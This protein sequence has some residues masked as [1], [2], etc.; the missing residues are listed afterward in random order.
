M[1]GPMTLLVG[2]LF[3]SYMG[4]SV[5]RKGKFRLATRSGVEHV[6]LG[7]VLGPLVLGIIERSWTKLFEPI[8]LVGAAWLGFLAGARW[9]MPGTQR[10]A[11]AV[12]RGMSFALL[13]LGALGAA[14]FGAW[15]FF[16]ERLH[17]GNRV[18]EWLYIFVGVVV[19]LAVAT[20]ASVASVL[21]RL[22]IADKTRVLLIRA[23][24][25]MP[26]VPVLGAML[27]FGVDSPWTNSKPLHWVVIGS[28]VAPILVGLIL[29]LV[30]A[31]LASRFVHA[32][33]AW[34]VILGTTLFGA[35]F[36]IRTGLSAVATLFFLG[37]T[38]SFFPSIRPT[39]KVFTDTTERPV[40]LPVALVLGASLRADVDVGVLALFGVILVVRTALVLGTG[41][42]ASLGFRESNLGLSFGCLLTMPAALPLALR[43]E[44]SL[45]GDS[46]YQMPL[47]IL[48]CAGFAVHELFGQ[49][50]LRQ[51]DASER[52]SQLPPEP[53]SVARGAA[54]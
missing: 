52:N 15:Q 24:S 12:L 32:E 28:V 19:S 43:S 5:G 34:G 4:G 42:L 20:P 54:L 16:A 21:D 36:S 38:L 22:T 35:G 29:G 14:F 10:S 49:L 31:G 53:K 18:F 8:V 50:A 13:L 30:T 40:L 1:T 9:L 46:P 39:L 47:L 45:R 48:A 51:L 44:A 33:Q 23:A 11:K 37:L 2:L 26:F 17:Y 41:W 25:V 27:L 6:I 7:L 3:L